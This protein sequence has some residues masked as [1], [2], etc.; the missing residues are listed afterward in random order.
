MYNRECNANV[1]RDRHKLN[2]EQNPILAF[3][4][5]SRKGRLFKITNYLLIRW[6][7]NQDINF[8][9]KSIHF[10]INKLLNLDD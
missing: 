7:I 3:T 1:D 6:I 8:Q 9:I 5:F 4:F 2:V 10:N